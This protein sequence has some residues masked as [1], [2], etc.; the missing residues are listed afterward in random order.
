MDATVFEE[1]TKPGAYKAIMLGL[2][3]LN[4]FILERRKIGPL[5]WNIPYEFIYS[6]LSISQAQLKMYLDHYDAISW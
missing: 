2:C 1:C 5:G 4:A 3:I 6:D